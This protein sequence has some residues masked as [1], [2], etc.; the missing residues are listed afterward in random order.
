MISAVLVNDR[1]LGI[2]NPSR[3]KVSINGVT[4]EAERVDSGDLCSLNKVNSIAKIVLSWDKLTVEEMETLCSIFSIDVADYGS[5][6]TPKTIN[7]LVY[8]ITARLP[9]GIKSFTA[10]V[11]DT[12]EGELLDYSGSINSELLGGEYWADVSISL[13]G[14]GEGWN[15]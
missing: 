6:Y 11:G 15:G 13:I 7:D 5:T 12:I 3:V 14:T 8:K 10:Y 4:S 2:S 1:P 9:M